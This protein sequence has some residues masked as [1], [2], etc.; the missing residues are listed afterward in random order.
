M[1]ESNEKPVSSAESQ[2]LSEKEKVLEE[3]KTFFAE[4]AREAANPDSGN[5]YVDGA[6]EFGAQ[7]QAYVSN[8]EQGKFFDD[9][10]FSVEGKEKP[11]T[12][13]SVLAYLLDARASNVGMAQ[14]CMETG[15]EDKAK[16]Y[17]EAAEKVTNLLENLVLFKKDKKMLG[18]RPDR[19]FIADENGNVAI[20]GSGEERLAEINVDGSL[21]KFVEV[22]ESAEEGKL[23]GMISELEQQ[24]KDIDGEWEALNKEAVEEGR[25]KYGDRGF[26]FNS[27]EWSDELKQKM[28]AVKR[29]SEWNFRLKNEVTNPSETDAAPKSL[30]DIEK[31][32]RQRIAEGVSHFNQQLEEQAISSNDRIKIYQ[33]WDKNEAYPEEYFFSHVDPENGLVYVS[34]AKV[35]KGGSNSLIGLKIEDIKK[36]NKGEGGGFD[37]LKSK[38][39]GRK[40]KSSSQEK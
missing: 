16:K 37:K 35:N 4:R 32:L 12:K 13:K 40:S 23:E 20:E 5:T 36:I 8:I 1:P 34:E 7:M 3:A 18:M 31:S 33:N 22:E 39:K 38:L 2:E 6:K 21:D 24:G 29:K 9:A 28:D 26:S 14:L 10:K 15:A 27:A 17:Q 25:K 11:V 19:E 30:E